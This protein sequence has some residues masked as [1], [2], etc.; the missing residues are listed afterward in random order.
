MPKT[1]NAPRGEQQVGGRIAR[2]TTSGR[3][4]AQAMRVITARIIVA[5]TPW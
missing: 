2:G 4:Y 3:L 1:R 5:K